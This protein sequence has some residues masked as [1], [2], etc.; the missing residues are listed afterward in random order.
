MKITLI[1]FLLKDIKN[2]IVLSYKNI[3]KLRLKYKFDF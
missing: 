2:H 3:G 1:M